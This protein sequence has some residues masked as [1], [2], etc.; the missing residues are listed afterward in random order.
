MVLLAARAALL[1]SG[2][3]PVDRLRTMGS[4]GCGEEE[5][6]RARTKEAYA[7]VQEWTLPLEIIVRGLVNGLGNHRLHGSDLWPRVVCPTHGRG[8]EAAH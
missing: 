1:L 4:I 6:V 2:D 5:P 7:S 8:D 3:C